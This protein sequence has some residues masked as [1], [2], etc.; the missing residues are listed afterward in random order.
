MEDIA[1]L[2][3]V[4][5]QEFYLTSPAKYSMLVKCD[6]SSNIPYWPDMLY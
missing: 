6:Y 5:E 2:P 1:E 4:I 3:Q